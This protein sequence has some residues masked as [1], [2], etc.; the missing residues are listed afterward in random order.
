MFGGRGKRKGRGG[1][2]STAA[3]ELASALTTLN[4]KPFVRF[5]N[6]E[7]GLVSSLAKDT[8]G[9]SGESIGQSLA[10]QFPDE[11]RKL[12]LTI[13]HYTHSILE[14]ERKQFKSAHKSV[15]SSIN[16]LNQYLADCP[17]AW[18]VP[19]I[20]PILSRARQIAL[21]CEG[22]REKCL[23]EAAQSFL[24]T[25]NRVGS[26]KSAFVSSKRLGMVTVCN[27]ISKVAFYTN[28]MGVAKS[29]LQMLTRLQTTDK[30]SILD[31]IPNG[32]KVTHLFY[33][34][35]LQMLDQRFPEAESLLSDAFL[36]CPDSAKYRNNKTRILV[37][38]LTV[39]LV[40]GKYPSPA[41]L[42][43]YKLAATFQG[44][45]SAM[46]TGDVSKFDSV[47]ASRASFFAKL[48]IYVILHRARLVC[49][50]TLVRRTHHTM[51]LL[52]PDDDNFRSRI[53]IQ[54]LV[55][56]YKSI[57]NGKGIDS[58]EVECALVCLI[59]NGQIKGY[60]SR[61]HGILVLLKKGTPFPNCVPK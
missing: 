11:H 22:E 32:E 14:S 60:I 52:K 27:N 23:D 49:F 35:R 50:Q 4:S 51:S 48:G 39:K 2:S 33:N 13:G 10:S 55:D 15:R 3:G 54:V 44:L 31:V 47:M 29:A 36:S 43:S 56:V 34:G 12:A 24:Q 21:S 46:Q 9:D 38:L 1:G 61:E 53:K 7:G 6:N 45:I 40:Q 18:M 5:L 42:R 41:L 30:I 19:L 57:S 20:G 58:E 28:N 37:F 25:L 17:D 59:A 16:S 8:G 26:D